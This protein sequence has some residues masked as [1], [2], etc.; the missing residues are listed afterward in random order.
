MQGVEGKRLGDGPHRG[1]HGRRPSPEQDAPRHAKTPRKRVRVFKEELNGFQFALTR[2]YFT[3]P[4]QEAAGQWR[5]AFHHRE[6]L[7]LQGL[8]GVREGVRRR[9]AAPGH[10]DHRFGQAAARALGPLDRPAE[11]A[12]KYIRVDD[13]EE[14][15]GTLE[16]ILLDKSNY[17]PSPAATAPAWVARKRR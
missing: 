9:R 13:L 2:P 5:A 12:Q 8:H 10:A 6:P 15:I 1:R 16:T 4:E 7:H 14:R 17:L 3:L 11:H